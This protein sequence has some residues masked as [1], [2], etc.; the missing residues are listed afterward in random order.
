MY[1]IKT[2]SAGAAKL[3]AKTQ[4]ELDYTLRYERDN[5]TFSAAIQEN[6]EDVRP[7]YNY[8]ETQSKINRLNQKIRTIKHAINAFNVST[9]VP[10]LNMTVD[11]VLVLLP[12]LSREKERLQSM[13]LV[14]LKKRDS[15]RSNFIEYQY[16]NFDPV[17][18]KKNFNNVVDFLSRAQL[19]LDQVN[20]NIEFEIDIDE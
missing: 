12:Q 8:L 13:A 18:A 6:L 15:Y 14:P 16:A 17:E 3:L 19:G 2:T 5:C 20:H 9:P 11:E 4:Q 1:M 7:N 10:G